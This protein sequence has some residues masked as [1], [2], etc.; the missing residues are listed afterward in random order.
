[1]PLAPE[2]LDNGVKEQFQDAGAFS[3]RVE[4]QRPR[5]SA[6]RASKPLIELVAQKFPG[7]VEAGFNGLGGAV[8]D[9]ADF[10]MGE[11]FVFREDKRGAEFFGEVGDSLSNCVGGFSF[12]QVFARAGL[13]HRDCVAEVG[14]G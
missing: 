14:S 13:V 5:S 6:T 7:A 8:K 3:K 12:L 9:C 1:M 2:D 4:S 11:F 10:T